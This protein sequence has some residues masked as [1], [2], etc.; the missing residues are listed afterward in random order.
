MRKQR[1]FLSQDIK[2]ICQAENRILHH[3]T[4]KDSNFQCIPDINLQMW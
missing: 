4:Q 1:K 3:A 2:F